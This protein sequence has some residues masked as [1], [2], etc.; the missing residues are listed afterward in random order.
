MSTTTGLWAHLPGT[1]HGHFDVVVDLPTGPRQ[2][3][4]VPDRPVRR[5]RRRR[6]GVV[7]PLLVILLGVTLTT[8]ALQPEPAEAQAGTVTRLSGVTQVASG[9]R[10]GC[11]RLSDGRAR[12]WGDGTSGALGNGG[13]ARSSHGTL[14]QN[15][16]G[17]GPLTGVRQ[18]ATG[19]EHSCALL[20]NG[21]VRCWGAN[22]H[23]QLGD[24]SV[25]PRTLPV[26]VR[27]NDGTSPLT[28]ATAITAGGD[29]TCA[30][31]ASRRVV[32]W[33]RD[34]RGQVGT[35]EPSPIRT[36]AWFVVTTDLVPV[37]G[38]TQL[39]SGR[40]STCARLVNGTASCWGVNDDGQ[41]GIGTTSPIQ[42]AVLVR[43]GPDA[44]NLG[45]VTSVS[46][47]HDHA[48]ARLADGQARCW[49]DNEQGRLGDG[50]GSPRL[51]PT[52]VIAPTG[53]AR[54]A[55]VKAIRAGAGSTCALLT[56]GGV[57]CW[58]YGVYGTLGNG[59]RGVVN[60]RPVPVRTPAGTA[61]LGSATQLA[62]GELTACVRL[63]N[64]QAR[65]WGYGDSGAAGNP[66]GGDEAFPLPVP[67]LQGP[68]P[69]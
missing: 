15:R 47:G 69:E 7:L 1:H 36:Y 66:T 54:L 34:D 59:T 19:D 46:V 65:C 61:D 16:A 6:P 5:R 4:H 32:C 43:S 31:L 41:L 29:N 49:G 24:G 12:C 35:E 62:L 40:H 45:R 25:D 58:G 22:E 33:G 17:T 20:T 37:E 23:G 2:R 3:R 55:G 39:E 11:A 42:G 18:V 28:R 44:G 52:P 64:G 9:G 14:V 57:R 13:N 48:C 68:R 21:Q 51:Y 10:H 8:I 63:A 26:A 60:L 38:V 27:G 53:T 50:T 30:L 56:G 67:V